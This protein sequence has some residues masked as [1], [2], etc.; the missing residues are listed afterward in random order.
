MRI[1][2]SVIV[3]APWWPAI[4]DAVDR[5]DVDVRRRR[6][7]RTA[8]SRRRTG[9]APQRS[10]LDGR[11]EAAAR[12]EREHREHAFVDRAG[13]DVV[14]G[15]G[16]ER[17]PGVGQH[18]ALELRLG[19]QEHVARGRAEQRVGRLGALGVQRRLQLRPVREDRTGVDVLG[20]AGRADREAQ[21]PVA[22]ARRARARDRARCRWRRPSPCAAAARCPA[23]LRACARRCATIA[24][25]ARASG[26]PG[27]ANRRTLPIP[28][29]G[30]SSG[31][32]ALPASA[33]AVA[34]VLGAAGALTCS[35]SGDCAAGARRLR[36]RR[37]VRAGRFD[38]RATWRAPAGLRGSVIGGSDAA[39]ARRR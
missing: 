36:R 19:Q 15:A 27:C 20:V 39:E 13:G 18:R 7:A 31:S 35:V 17:D 12:E 21:V 33:A 14:A 11:L 4:G 16:V 23:L 34:A 2:R 6:T 29:G 8:R 30:P 38:D 3:P 24:A 25:A 37:V 22:R 9:P 26:L 28:A 10:T 5:G 32:E 1:V